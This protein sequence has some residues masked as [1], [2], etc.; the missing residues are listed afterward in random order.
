LGR[1]QIRNGRP[2]GKKIAFETAAGAKYYYYS[3]ARIA[4]VAAEGGTPQIVTEAF[5]EDPGLI[6]WGP[7]GIYFAA[8]QKTYA[9]L[10]RLNPE[11]KAIEKLSAPDHLCRILLFVFRAITRKWRIARRSRINTPRCSRPASRRGRARS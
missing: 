11:T 9:H 5:D 10:F 7:D 4:V 6:G 2:T 1:I 3:N 8:E